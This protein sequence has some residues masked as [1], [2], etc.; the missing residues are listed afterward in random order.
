MQKVIRTTGVTPVPKAR[1]LFSMH[2]FV[3][4][5]REIYFYASCR[6]H[7]A[8]LCMQCVRRLYSR[9]QNEAVNAVGEGRIDEDGAGQLTKV[10]KVGVDAPIRGE[11]LQH[12]SGRD[13]PERPLRKQ[14]G[15]RTSQS[16]RVERFVYHERLRP[17][18]P[19]RVAMAPSGGSRNRKSREARGD[20]ISINRRINLTKSTARH[21]R[22]RAGHPGGAL[23][24]NHADVGPGCE[25]QA[26]A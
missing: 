13:S 11:N 23:V 17:C 7:Y 24:D 19:V 20:G 21:A 16:P 12:A 8:L 14:D 18:C 3:C 10:D 5:A 25:G 2:G 9:A 22:P 6:M 26:R 1:R 15:Q 4:I